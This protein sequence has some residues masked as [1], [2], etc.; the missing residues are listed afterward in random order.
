V[1]ASPEATIEA[2]PET[3]DAGRLEDIRAAGFNRLSMG[4]QSFDAAVLSSLERAHSPG[5]V[6]AAV[7]EARAAGFDNVNVDLIYGAEAETLAS[8]SRTLEEAVELGPD[9]VSA[10]AL[11]VEPA[12]PLGRRVASGAAPPPDA[13][14][15]A[16]MFELACDLLASSGYR[17][18]E[19][20]NWARPGRECRHNLGYWERRPF[21]GLGAGAHSGR[22]RSRWWNVRGPQAYLEMVARGDRPV[23]GGEELSR[24][25]A[26]FEELLLRM[27]TRR[28]VPATW[29]ADDRRI[30]PL[31]DEG[32]VRRSGGSIVPTE[33]GLLLLNEV[34]LALTD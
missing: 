27:R 6:A 7:R 3:L 9:H 10:Y 24:K 28:G 13:D 15:Q 25:D 16:D 26:R 2:N 18:Y 12:T 19:V 5:R 32:L 31:V 23:A 17:H 11:T 1:V 21:L 33:H 34:V 22:G 29:I 4:A 8:W 20:S 30:A 14:V